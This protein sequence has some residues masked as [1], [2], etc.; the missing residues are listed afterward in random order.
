VAS[1]TAF[2]GVPPLPADLVSVVMPLAQAWGR[3][4]NMVC[5]PAQTKISLLASPF[6]KLRVRHLI[7]PHAELFEA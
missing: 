6:D 5:G 1:S 3:L 7:G 2:K 4:L